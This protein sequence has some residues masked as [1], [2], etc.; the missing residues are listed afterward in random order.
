M[1]I[2][3]AKR[4]EKQQQAKNEK[5]EIWYGDDFFKVR[6]QIVPEKLVEAEQHME[7]GDKW[8][9]TYVIIDFPATAKKHWINRLYDFKGNI[10][11]SKHVK[12]MPSDKMTKGVSESMVE[13]ES[14]L[15]SNITPERKKQVES[16]LKSADK[17]L[18]KLT[19]GDNDFVYY[20]H[21]Y[22]RIVADSEA[23]LKSMAKRLKSTFHKVRLKPHIPNHQQMEAFESMLPVNENKLPEYTYRNM[24]ASA[25]AT[26][27]PYSESEIFMEEGYVKGTNVKSGNIVVVDQF[28]LPN[29]NE[30][31]L[32]ASGQGKSGY[33]KMDVLRSYKDGIRIFIIDPEREYTEIMKEIGG[34]VVVVSPMAD[35][36]I[37]PMEIFYSSLVANDKEEM[38]GITKSLLHQRISRL[39]IFFR[40]IKKDLE[41]LESA[42][43]E[44]ALIE[45][46]A[47]YK[48]ENNPDGIHWN[49]DFSKLTSTDYPT[50]KEL[51]EEL[52]QEDELRNFRAI[53]KS[54]VSGAYSKMFS[55][56]TTVNLKSKAICFDL[57]DLEDDSDVQPA[58]M[59]NVLNFL[60]DEIT[61]DNKE[62]KRLYIDE[63]HIL[64]DPKNPR[65]MKFLFNIW[66]R[67]RKY[68]GGAT[69]ATQQ[70]AD[71]LS[72]IEGSRNYGKAIIGNSS[73][74]L[75]LCLESND[76]DDLLSNN[77]IKLSEEEI[78]IL[79][80]MEKRE[81]IYIAGNKRVNI[82]I[83]LDDYELELINPEAYKEKMQRGA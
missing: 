38:G 28:A 59:F 8:A 76:I 53:F 55:G 4:K 77:V 40:L 74:K 67:I 42:L 72:A 66:K 33:L 30:F 10:S 24:D 70:I 36:V 46:Y 80:K 79:S 50:F 5:V 14:R 12:P 82:R 71:L 18:D 31:V 27:F 51:Y 65:A 48:T 6:D 58:A 44:D 41:P 21:L 52:K 7:H 15:L 69:A 35:E 47:N 63:T 17:L 32:G 62:R 3:K 29:H 20:V 2:L 26:M 39:N 61:K 25:L 37:N 56:H 68:N 54:Y 64:A 1:G 43:I 19:E 9:R 16:Q 34:Q 13:L 83:E 11:I 81:G 57:K 49:T 78:D 23:E 22:V 60:W 75:L 45:T 73:A